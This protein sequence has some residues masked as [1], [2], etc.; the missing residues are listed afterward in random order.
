MAHS[1]TKKKNNNSQHQNPSQIPYQQPF[2]I[3]PIQTSQSTEHKQELDA[4]QLE[5]TTST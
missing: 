3:S 5:L 4:K 2:H 1:K